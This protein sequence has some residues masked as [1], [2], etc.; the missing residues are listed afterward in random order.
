MSDKIAIPA[1]RWCQ[2]NCKDGYFYWAGEAFVCILC[3][4][5]IAIENE[6]KSVERN[7]MANLF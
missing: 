5:R 2:N 4:E 1:T 6:K 7:L 3:A